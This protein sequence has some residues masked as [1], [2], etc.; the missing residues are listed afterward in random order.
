MVFRHVTIPRKGSGNN[1]N[2]ILHACGRRIRD[3]FYLILRCPATDP[4]RRSLF[5]DSLGPGELFGF[6]GLIFFRHAPSLGKGQV[7]TTGTIIIFY[8]NGVMVEAFALQSV[9]LEF[10]YLVES[11]QITL[12]IVLTGRRSAEKG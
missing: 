11:Y 2:R 3:T 12:K 8:H 6:W 1:N 10:V 9:D 4:L 7:T 5:G